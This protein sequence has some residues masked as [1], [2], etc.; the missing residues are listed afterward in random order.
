M[1]CVAVYSENP[2]F[3]MGVPDVELMGHTIRNVGLN[4]V[5]YTNVPDKFDSSKWTIIP[6]QRT[7]YP[8][9][10]CKMEVFRHAGP[11]IY[12]DIDTLWIQ[13]PTGIEKFLHA[14]IRNG[15]EDFLM[16]SMPS[17]R[18][19]WFASIMAWNFSMEWLYDVYWESPEFHH[20]NPKYTRN[21]GDVAV[22][23]QDFIAEFVS[24]SGRQIVDVKDVQSGVH[25]WRRNLAVRDDMREIGHSRKDMTVIFFHSIPR[26]M[27]AI[28]R[29]P[30]LGRA[31]QWNA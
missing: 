5:L 18:S 7:G 9:W 28:A 19:P 2:E 12:V 31:V 21:R 17:K 15:R 11:C 13:R 30:W 1:D 10:W 27:K 8:T 20:Q 25:N 26:P 6:F 24:R 4:P 23:E 16:V 3:D 14:G 29:N 22:Y